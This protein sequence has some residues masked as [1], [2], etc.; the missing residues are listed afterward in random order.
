MATT[1]DT[2]LSGE[3]VLAGYKNQLGAALNIPGN[4]NI[5]RGSASENVLSGYQDQ[6]DAASRLRQE[7][8]KPEAPE[9]ADGNTLGQKKGLA[10]LAADMKKSAENPSA[11]GGISGG[12]STKTAQLLRVAWEN[13]LDPFAI[14]LALAY[15]NFHVFGNM[16]LGEKLFCKLGEEWIP[17]NFRSSLGSFGGKAFG[18][19]EKIILIV[20]DLIVLFAL[21]GILA[22]LVEIASFYSDSLVGKAQQIFQAIST[23]GWGTVSAIT[24]LF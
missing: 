10:A 5:N 22:I 6:L 18:L 8:A 7:R 3:Q 17:N 1:T 13:M 19:L 24:S 9:E 20:L 12:A 14:P 23:L 11:A 15:I 21:L 16:V 2:R 4:Q